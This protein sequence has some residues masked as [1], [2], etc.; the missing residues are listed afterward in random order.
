MKHTGSHI[1]HALI[2]SLAL[3]GPAYADDH[4]DFIK[5]ADLLTQLESDDSLFIFD[6]RSQQEYDKGHIS[7]SLSLPLL[8]ITQERLNQLDGLGKD[9]SIVTYCGC[10]H[11]LSSLAAEKLS[12]LQY[13]N[14]RVLDEGFWHWKNQKYPVQSN[15]QAGPVSELRV[16]GRL[17]AENKPVG[18]IDIYLLHVGTGQLEA[19]RTDGDGN[20]AMDL[21]LYGYQKNDLFV[22]YADNMNTAPI[23]TFSTHKQHET[24]VLVMY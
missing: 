4:V 5:A 19:T 18:N 15:T 17:V 2:F 24:N 10:P 14:V 3:A 8:S 16:E 23:G 22:F 7:G 6:V 12:E 1:I 13:E 11:H 9:S 21:H 20:Y